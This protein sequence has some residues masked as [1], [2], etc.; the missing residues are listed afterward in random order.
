MRKFRTGDKVICIDA[1]AS[2]NRLEEGLIYTIKTPMYNHEYYEG[3]ELREIGTQRHHPWMARRFR[4]LNS[5]L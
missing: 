3:V 5:I 4:N 2:N 1:E